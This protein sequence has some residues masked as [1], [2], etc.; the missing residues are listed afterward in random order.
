MIF[1]SREIPYNLRSVVLSPGAKAVSQLNDPLQRGLKAT[2]WP[3]HCKE[4]IFF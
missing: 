4:G 2:S 1:L 3:F